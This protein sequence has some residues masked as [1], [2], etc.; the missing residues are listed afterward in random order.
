MSPFIFWEVIEGTGSGFYQ[1]KASRSCVH[2]FHQ[3]GWP[4]AA[5]RIIVR[6]PYSRRLSSQAISL[7]RFIP[8]LARKRALGSRKRSRPLLT[9]WTARNGVFRRRK[10]QA[11]ELY[12]M[13]FRCIVSL[14]SEHTAVTRSIAD[15]TRVRVQAHQSFGQETCNSW[16][17]RKKICSSKVRRMFCSIPFL[18]LAIF[19]HHRL[20]WDG[21]FEG[22][23]SASSRPRVYKRRSRNH[24]SWSWSM[25]FHEFFSLWSL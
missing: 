23:I 19:I 5:R 9:N 3:G 17:K 6:I 2:L 25:A 21:A 12:L 10:C 20:F 24:N 4:N 13:V 22:A 18:H 1:I 14:E 8:F 11:L 15:T 16:L 7:R